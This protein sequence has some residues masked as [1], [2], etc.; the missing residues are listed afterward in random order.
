M[1]TALAPALA[2]DMV[3]STVASWPDNVAWAFREYCD[4]PANGRS[5][6]A[7][8][9]RFDRLAA[10]GEAVPTARARTLGEWS[11]RYGWQRLAAV[12]IAERLAG[13]RVDLMEAASERGQ[14]ALQ[15]LA[16]LLDAVRTVVT[17]TG[18]IVTA[19]DLDTQLKAA[20]A[21]LDRAGL[22]PAKSMSVQ[23]SG[24]DGGPI[25][26]FGLTASIDVSGMSPAELLDALRRQTTA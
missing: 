21:L 26:F 5:L 2:G 13:R 6:A 22:A 14:A 7:L 19:A 23:H 16:E 11:A 15:K 18:D 17:P 25:P 20:V 10:A 12:V 8:A 3:A 9:A 1:S 4:L 24:P